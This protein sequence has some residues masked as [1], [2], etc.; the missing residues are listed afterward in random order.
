MTQDDRTPENGPGLETE[1]IAARLEAE[2][3]IPYPAFRGELRRRLLSTASRTVAPRRVHL[4][5][6]G[7]SAAGLALL[8]TAAI[9]LAGLGPFAA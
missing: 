6:T 2:R 8:T 1:A 5:I 4:L 7:Y 3:P 9:G